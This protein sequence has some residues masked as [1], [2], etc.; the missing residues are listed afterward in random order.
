MELYTGKNP[1]L[2]KNIN[3]TVNNILNFEED[4]IEKDTELLDEDIK[5][6]IRLM[7]RK[8]TTKRAK[9]ALEVLQIMGVDKN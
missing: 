6:A 3:E 2:G 9:T 8:S 1:F 4:S 5:Q 7:L